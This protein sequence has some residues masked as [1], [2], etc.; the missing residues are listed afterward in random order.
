MAKAINYGQRMHK[1]IC[2]V[3]ADVLSLVAREGLS[4]DHHFFITFHTTHPGVD[5]SDSLRQRNP[6]EMTIVLQEWFED[7][8]VMKDR[9]SVTLSF[10]NIPH[11]IVIP[12]DAIKTFVDP[13]VEFGI[14]LDAHETEAGTS[15]QPTK[16]KPA[17]EAPK[18]TEGE[19]VSLDRFRKP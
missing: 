14:R 17:Q 18:S 9:C 1:A 6:K 10:G 8:A 7:L 13:S 3:L 5:M 2:Q 4:G 16:P 19:V 12:F 15:A 11:Q